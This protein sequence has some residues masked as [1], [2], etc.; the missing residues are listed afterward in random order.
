MDAD[1]KRHAAGVGQNLMIW[2]GV[3]AFCLLL[4][5]DGA[6]GIG[7]AWR[8][9]QGIGTPGVFTAT[10][11]HRNSCNIGTWTSDDGRRTVHEVGILDLPRGR[12]H[13]GDTFR[14]LYTG[15][16]DRVYVPRGNAYLGFLWTLVAGSTGVFILA[17]ALF[18]GMRRQ[19][20]ES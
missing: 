9:H 6:M 11:C 17:A 7:P 1:A 8:A 15:D 18:A 13:E 3:P 14:A 12:V 5:M 4:L 16:S 19:R 10:T 2:V 20:A